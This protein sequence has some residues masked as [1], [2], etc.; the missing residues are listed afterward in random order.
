MATW[1]LRPTTRRTSQNDRVDI[2][3]DDGRYVA[4]YVARADALRMIHDPI[5]IAEDAINLYVEGLDRRDGSHEGAM[6]YAMEEIRDAVSTDLD[7]LH[8][9][10]AADLKAERRTVLLGA[11]ISPDDPEA[12]P[13]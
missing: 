6:A 2:H 11:G 12:L 10:M 9:E 4:G 3:A 13:F 8:D 5:Q 7:A 1:R